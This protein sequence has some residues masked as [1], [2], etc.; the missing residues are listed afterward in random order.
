MELH[1]HGHLPM[2]IT[3]AL[4]S[5][6][7]TVKVP[8]DSPYEE[9]SSVLSSRAIRQGI[10]ALFKLPK[11]VEFFP[12]RGD[13]VHE[14][15]QATPRHSIQNMNDFIVSVLKLNTCMTTSQENFFKRW[16]L[17]AAS[18][19]YWSRIKPRSKTHVKA[20]ILGMAEYFHGGHTQKEKEM[21]PFSDDWLHALHAFSEWQFIY[22]DQC[23]ADTL[24]G[25]PFDDVS[26]C[27]L[28]DG[29]KAIMYSIDLELAK[30]VWCKFQSTTWHD[31][32][33]RFLS[34]VSDLDHALAPVPLRQPVMR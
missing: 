21:P 4:V 27:R 1:R 9:N 11:V 34:I 30:T 20:L 31:T 24:L 10:Y 16:N 28:Y 29:Y 5:S 23:V 19:M 6:R 13:L 32:L 18:L 14:V 8:A 2:F 17:V 22:H 12:R 26:P 25:S 7:V 33:L 15:V 3:Q